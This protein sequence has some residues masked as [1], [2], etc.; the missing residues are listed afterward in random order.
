MFFMC[1]K[2]KV[3]SKTMARVKSY[4]TTCRERGNAILE[5]KKARPEHHEHRTAANPMLNK[6]ITG[7]ETLLHRRLASSI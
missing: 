6:H 5:K 7:V 4:P 2:V 3:K 1:G